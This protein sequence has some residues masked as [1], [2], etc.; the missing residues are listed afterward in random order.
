[1]PES[2]VAGTEL[3][4]GQLPAAFT[5]EGLTQVNV[6]VDGRALPRLAKSWTWEENG[7]RLR[8]TLRPDVKFHDGTRLTSAIAANALK[9]AIARP[10]NRALYP[11]LS[12]ITAVQS[13]GNL[14]LVIDLSQP[15]AFLPEELDLPLEIGRENAGT[16]AFRLVKGDSSGVLLERFDQYYL[17]PP[18]IEQ[19]VIRPFDTLRTAWTSLLRGEVDMVTEIP[20]EAVQFIRNDDIEVISFARSYQFLIAFNSQRPPFTSSV[21]RRALNVA[22]NR[23][24]LIA[25]VLHGE[26]EPATGPL[27]PR[28]WAYDSS[29]PGYN[30]DPQL[31]R[32]LLEAAGYANNSSPRSADRP[33]ARFRFT[34][35]VPADFSLW[36]RVGLDVQK[37]LYDVGV[38]VQF[39]VLPAQEYD[40][41]IRDGDFDAVLVNMISGPT[42]GRPFIFWRSARQFRGLNTFGYENPET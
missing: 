5:L 29:V 35:L 10:A 15:S 3:G 30:F 2:G 13:D 27:W 18:A 12:D 17:G 9:L 26:G 40:S 32:S 14:D 1:V 39:D 16:G 31:A 4:L 24:A 6:S 41:R 37:Q 21:V 8:L 11:S 23:D 19:V 25:K 42:F 20:P 22:I 33:P 34:C 38:D 28:H 7:L 36:E